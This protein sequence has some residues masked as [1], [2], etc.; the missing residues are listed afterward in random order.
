VDIDRLKAIN[1]GF[2]HKAGDRAIVAV[3]RILVKH[4]RAMDTVAR[5]GGDEFA[6]LLPETSATRASVLSRRILKEVARHNNELTGSLAVSIGITELN[7]SAEVKSDDMLAAG[8][9]AL[10]RA[11]AAGGGHAAVA[12]AGLE[13]TTSRS[14]HVVLMEGALLIEDEKRRAAVI[15]SSSAAV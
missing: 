6:V 4:V 8:D 2:G 15:S 9:A 12:L 14:Q 11:K 13:P 7:A 1:D 5:V 10:Y 3:G